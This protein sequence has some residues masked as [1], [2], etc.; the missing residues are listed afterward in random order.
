MYFQSLS[1]SDVCA[2]MLLYYVY[3]DIDLYI[4]MHTCMR[5]SCIHM[6]RAHVIPIPKNMTEYL[7]TIFSLP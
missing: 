1:G 7:F 3:I 5:A 4:Y 6:H 2:H